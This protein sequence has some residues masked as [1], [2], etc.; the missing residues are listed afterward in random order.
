[1]FGENRAE[2]GGPGIPR[3]DKCS[4]PDPASAIALGLSV[5]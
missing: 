3:W 1:V 2:E 4:P 5:S